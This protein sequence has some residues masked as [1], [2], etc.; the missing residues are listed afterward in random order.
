L[1]LISANL[2]FRE[3]LCWYIIIYESSVWERIL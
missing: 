3:G 2:L 1:Y